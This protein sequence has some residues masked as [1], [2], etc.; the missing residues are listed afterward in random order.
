MY[1]L[2]KGKE[3]FTMVEGPFAGRSFEPG[4]DYSEIP[5]GMAG[6]FEAN[7]EAAAP[8]AGEKKPAKAEVAKPAEAENKVKK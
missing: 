2:K 5:P 6:K 4:K 8:A 3:G 1:Q 7:K